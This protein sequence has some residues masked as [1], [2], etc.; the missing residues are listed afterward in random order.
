MRRRLGPAGLLRRALGEAG[1]EVLVPRGPPSR[2][3]L[4]APK[5]GAVYPVSEARAAYEAGGCR[6]LGE[7]D[8]ILGV[9]E[10][11]L[12][13]VDVLARGP[14]GLAVVG[15]VK[16]R[17]APRILSRHPPRV[18]EAFLAYHLDEPQAALEAWEWLES[19][20]AVSSLY[21]NPASVAE[22]V[23]EA[24]A[25]YRALSPRRMVLA[26]FLL[27]TAAPLAGQVSGMVERAASYASRCLGVPVE[28]AL[29][30][31]RP[32]AFIGTPGSV[33]LE[34]RGPGCGALPQGPQPA[35]EDVG[36]YAGCGEC[37]Y[38]RICTAYCSI[39]P[40]FNPEAGRV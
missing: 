3:T 16:T 28:P 27:C 34:C 25:A 31:L 6:E 22:L 29:V 9:G 2:R 10:R 24:G 21:D 20:G 36:L 8:S 35:G 18:L 11:A 26:A 5:A 37:P 4:R 14:G 19:R 33:T 32:D 1:Y 12:V 39:N 17:L 13:E 30:V 38:R 15:E 23:R 7:I 40:G